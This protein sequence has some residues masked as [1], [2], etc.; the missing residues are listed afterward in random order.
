MHDVDSLHV[1]DG[2]FVDVDDIKPL[3]DINGDGDDGV[4]VDHRR[5][6]RGALLQSC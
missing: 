6:V 3:L 2:G 4:D 5:F 1:K